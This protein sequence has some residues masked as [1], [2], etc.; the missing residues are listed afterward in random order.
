V[1][2]ARTQTARA[3]RD[4]LIAGGI[5]VAGAVVAIADQGELRGLPIWAVIAVVVLAAAAYVRA[6][7]GLM[8]RGEGDAGPAVERLRKMAIIWL[9]LAV[10]LGIG[11]LIGPV[12][13]FREAGAA[14]LRLRDWAT[15]AVGV[16]IVVAACVRALRVIR[17]IAAEAG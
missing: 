2:E 11:V 9:V 16:A 10:V 14:G 13:A 15:A 5:A 8:R 12:S 7:Y 6:A 4:Y 17:G 1:V 3:K